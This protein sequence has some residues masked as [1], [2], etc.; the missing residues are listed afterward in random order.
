M[1]IRS[2]RP[3]LALAA[4]ALAG[5]NVHAAPAISVLSSRPELVSG[6]TALVEVEGKPVTLNGNDVTAVF[7]TTSSGRRIG[8]LTGLR[9]GENRIQV[10]GE[11]LL[12]V[13][14][15]ATGPLFAGPHETPFYC[16]TD[17]FKLPASDQTLGAA[18]DS[19]CSV[20]TRVDWVYRS[21]SGEFKPL[22][23]D[24]TPTDV[25]QTRTSE[26]KTVPYIVRVETGTLNRA[27]YQTAAL[28]D[29]AVTAAPLIPPAAWNHRLVYTFGGG[30]VGG[31]YM[32]GANL[33]NHG[34]LED[35]MLRQGYAVASSSLNVFGNNC[36]MVIAAE[37]LAIVKEQFIKTYGRPAFTIGVGCSGGSEQLQPIGDAYPGLVDGIILGCSFPEVLG[38]MVLNLGDADLMTHYFQRTQL[39]WTDEQKAAATGYPNATTASTLAP[40][41]VRIKAEGGTCNVVIPENTRFSVA[42]NPTGVRCDLY[43]HTVNVFGPGRSP[44]EGSAS[45]ALPSSTTAVTSTRLRI[46]MR[47]IPASTRF[48]CEHGCRR[49][50]DPLL[51]M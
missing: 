21:R 3:V 35:L 23:S 47:T 51:T 20:K 24:L 37:T 41:S 46:A 9:A 33:G 15:P 25:A 43:D 6:G 13:N 29:P 11:S 26:G 10:G 34:I 40:Q 39:P 22:P 4:S 30:C 48:R 2:F 7:E 36:N 42:G 45:K 44:T 14:H 8:L 50:M 49:P 16:M 12:V 18:L 31:W 27:I 5:I 28:A 17:K 1:N 32:Q 38:A 19:D